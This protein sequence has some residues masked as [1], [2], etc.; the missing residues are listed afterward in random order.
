[1]ERHREGRAAPHTDQDR[2]PEA[3]GCKGPGGEPLASV[4]ARFGLKASASWHGI[5]RLVSICSPNVLDPAA[6]VAS[7]RRARSKRA[8][9][10][11][12]G[13]VCG[14]YQHRTGTMH[15]SEKSLKA[16]FAELA[17]YALG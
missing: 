10:A 11:F 17:C 15:T 4:S 13:I 7:L 1:V 9:N 14:Y 8:H 3:R 16:K 12:V 2:L 5:W 6:P